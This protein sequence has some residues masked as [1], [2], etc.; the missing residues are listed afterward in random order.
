M[1]VELINEPV[2]LMLKCS[3][4]GIVNPVRLLWHGREIRL[5]PK[6]ARVDKALGSQTRDYWCRSEDGANV[7]HLRWDVKQMEWTLVDVSEG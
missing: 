1:S 3:A 4:R 6:P 2:D 5:E 7:Y